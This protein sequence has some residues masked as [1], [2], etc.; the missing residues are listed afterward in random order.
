VKHVRVPFNRPYVAGREMGYIREALHSGHRHGDG[1]FT[2]QCHSWLEKTLGCPKALLTPSGTAALEMAAILADIMPGDEVI[3]PSFTFSSTANAFVLRGGTPVFVDIDPRTQN[4]DA[5][6]IEEAITDRTRAVVPVH[7]AGVGCD[8]DVI[9]SIAQRYKLLVIEDAAQALL[10]RY[11]GRYL[12]TIGHLGTLS[13]HDS[14]NCSAGEAGALLINDP[15][16][17]ERAEVVREK[18][19]SRPQFV[20][21]EVDK[22]T[23]IDVGSSY[24]PSEVTAAFLLAQLEEA[25]ATKTKRVAAWNVYEERLGEVSPGL[26]RRPYVPPECEHNGHLFYLVLAG[27]AIRRSFIAGMEQRGIVTLFHYVPLH[28]SVAGLR[29]GRPGG[30]LTATEVAGRGLVRLPLWRDMP[31]SLLELVITETGAVLSSLG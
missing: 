22:Y 9:M 10:A 2:Q 27:E 19:T 20:R 24:L 7:Y 23:W 14:K 8:M 31:F 16:F 3:M 13:F 11:R 30:V 21:G 12:G 28:N 17:I 6:K 1:A 5:S 4:I 15:R 26:A 29:Y 25:D 18:G